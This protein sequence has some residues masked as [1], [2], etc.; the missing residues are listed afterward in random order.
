[1]ASANTRT[2]STQMFVARVIPCFNMETPVT[3]TLEAEPTRDPRDA[4][5]F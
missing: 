5:S 1:V 3:T 4:W 2:P